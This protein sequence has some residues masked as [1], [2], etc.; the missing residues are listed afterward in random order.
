MNAWTA[1]CWMGTSSGYQNLTVYANT[2]N[3]AYDQ[4][5]NIYRAQQIIN[6]RRI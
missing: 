4:L 3:G 6:L 5:L 1:K 2:I